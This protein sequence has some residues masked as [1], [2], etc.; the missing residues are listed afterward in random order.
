M[1]ITG[2]TVEQF[3]LAVD[4]AGANYPLQRL[5]AEYGH[6]LKAEIGY[7]YSQ[8]RFSARVVPL[9]TGNCIWGF[10]RRRLTPGQRWSRIGLRRC[11]A[12]CWHAERDVLREVFATNPKAKVRTMYA[13]YSGID[14]FLRE[15]PKTARLNVGSQAKPVTPLDLCECVSGLP[16]ARARTHRIRQTAPVLVAH[17]PTPVVHRPTQEEQEMI[18]WWAEQSKRALTRTDKLREPR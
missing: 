12:V 8:T 9:F 14:G 7:E 13:K 15:Y 16:P 3:K 2:I 11:N 1:I 5:Y 6:N 17:K 18:Q 10:P 4:R